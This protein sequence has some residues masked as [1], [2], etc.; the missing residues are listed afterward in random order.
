LPQ[1]EAGFLTYC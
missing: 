1:D